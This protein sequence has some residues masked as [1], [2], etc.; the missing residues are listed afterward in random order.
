MRK[1]QFW[2]RVVWVG[3]LL[4][5]SGTALAQENSTLLVPAFQG[6]KPQGL[7][8]LAV[9]LL[10]AEGFDVVELEVT[11]TLTNKASNDSVASAARRLRARAVV[12]ALTE[13][14][15]RD[16]KSVFTVRDG[17]SGK[18]LGKFEIVGATLP[19]LQ[20][21][22]K[23]DLVAELLPLVSA[24]SGGAGP[25][26]A[27]NAP[28]PKPE[29]KPEPATEPAK[30]Q[31]PAPQPA[32]DEEPKAD[33]PADE[34]AEESG[35]ASDEGEAA[36]NEKDDQDKAEALVLHVG[37]AFL[38]R[39]WKIHDPLTNANDGPLL[40]AHSVPS[41]GLH[42]ALR[43]Y[44][45]AFANQPIVRHLGL[46]VDYARSFGAKTGV[47]NVTDDPD[48]ATRATT[49]QSLLVGLHAR[50]PLGPVQLG[51]LGAYGLDSL[52]LEGSKADV[53]IPDVSASSVRAALTLDVNIGSSTRVAL[54]GGYR[55]ALGFGGDEGQLQAP[56]WFK[57]TAGGAIDG[58][59]EVRQMFTDMFGMSLGGGLTHYVLDFGVA[60]EHVQEAEDADLP[61]PPIAGGATD[62][63]TS[64]DVNAVV[65]F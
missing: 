59:L 19:G 17:E 39:S 50:F 25:V 32:R 63:Y 15:K 27:A 21:A 34:P 56:E 41:F 22:Y 31:E 60:P 33:E 48:D 35:E 11:P 62:T 46:W 43:L 57:N 61:S 6:S 5:C 38:M 8:D 29:P 40:A 12:I 36:A 2:I 1:I 7:R 23:R 47:E 53:A 18:T 24:A 30:A 64:I 26:A 16:W 13:L 4:C 10:I 54:V 65:V 37:P 45:A 44:P 9:E 49:I 55:I 3:L 51:V 20:K 42:A 52:S 14:T 28:E 58:R